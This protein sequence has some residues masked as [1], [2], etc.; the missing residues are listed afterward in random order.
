MGSFSG[1][2][3]LLVDCHLVQFWLGA[4]DRMCRGWPQEAPDLKRRRLG[5][6]LG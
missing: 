6:G 4:W 2:S 1:V 5:I 3:T